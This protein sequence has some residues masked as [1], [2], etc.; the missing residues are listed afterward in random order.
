MHEGLHEPRSTLTVAPRVVGRVIDSSNAQ[1]ANGGQCQ[2]VNRSNTRREQAMR[3][4][5][6]ADTAHL[7][8]EA[9]EV[10]RPVAPQTPVQRTSK[11]RTPE[12]LANVAKAK[13]ELQL[14]SRAQE[15]P[16]DVSVA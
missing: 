11:A 9:A 12:C 7:L 1:S 6:V 2:G 15:A 3:T 8:T 10:T 14:G 5:L 16:A 13:V 4:E